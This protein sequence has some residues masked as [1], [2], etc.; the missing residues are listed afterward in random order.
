MC[1]SVAA[2]MA[3]IALPIELHEW[4][5]NHV[6]RVHLCVAHFVLCYNRVECDISRRYRERETK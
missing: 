1:A 2:M 5:N 4:N 3:A 6:I